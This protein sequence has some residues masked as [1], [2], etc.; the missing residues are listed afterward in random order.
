MASSNNKYV[1][2]EYLLYFWKKKW[3]FIV[4]PVFTS[5][6]IIGLVYAS[7][8]SANYNGHV[9][10]YAGGVNSPELITSENLEAKFNHIDPA[11][12]VSRSDKNIT[13]KVSGNS[14]EVVDKKLQ[15]IA[16]LYLMELQ[17]N[18][19]ERVKTTVVQ[20][21]SLE[22]RVVRLKEA[23][24]YYNKALPNMEEDLNVFDG[25]A[26]LIIEAEQQLTKSVNS[27]EKKKNDL[28]FFEEPKI[29]SNEVAESE[30]YIPES[31]LAGIIL[32]LILTVGL[33]ILLKYIEEARRNRE[34]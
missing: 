27:A 33:L 30:S 32:G 4:I 8:E 26:W 10:V 23:I 5:L 2:Y 7:K 3:F 15:E 25:I 14:R 21:E 17:Q 31:I 24:E 6:L 19:D 34:A 11:V 16:D 9:V 28:V 18:Y 13:I 1:L 12:D 20:L 29:L 22:E